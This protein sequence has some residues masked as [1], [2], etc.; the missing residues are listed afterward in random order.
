[1]QRH[2]A[3]NNVNVCLSTLPSVN[4]CANTRY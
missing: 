2:D 1:M 4:S 3:T